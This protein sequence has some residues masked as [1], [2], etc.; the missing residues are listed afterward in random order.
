MRLIRNIDELMSVH[1]PKEMSFVFRG[2]GEME[3]D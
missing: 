3:G 2:V 1:D